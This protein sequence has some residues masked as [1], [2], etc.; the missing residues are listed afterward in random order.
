MR[1]LSFPLAAGLAV[2]STAALAA[3]LGYEPPGPAP[4]EPAPAPWSG[5]YF[6]VHGGGLWIPP[7]GTSFNDGANTGDTSTNVGYRVGGSV[8]YDFSSA[9]GVEAE[10]SYGAVTLDTFEADGGGT[11]GVTGDASTLTIAGNV[12]IGQQW[13]AFRPYVG[14]G[15]GAA[16]ISLSVPDNVFGPDGVSDSDWTWMAQAFVGIDFMLTHNVSLGARYRFQYT[17]GTNFEDEGGTPLA[18]DAFGAHSI[19]AVLKARFGG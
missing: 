10:V 19:E 17:G 12:I 2:L 9:F 4:M 13:G 11:L 15:G 18:L 8:G 16:Q 14:I 1:K 6:S 5:I 7:V 3:D